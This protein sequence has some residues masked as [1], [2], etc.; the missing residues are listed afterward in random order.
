MK[1]I[2]FSLCTAGILF[3][4]NTLKA[5]TV[6][7]EDSFE[8]YTNF[9]I[10]NVGNWTLVDAD[11]SD[12]Y[13]IQGYSWTNAYAP[14]AFNVFNSTATTP[15]L[16]TTATS[17]WS[18]RTGQ[19]AMVS[20]AAI[21]PADGGSGPNNDWLIS[22][23]IQLTTDINNLSF[24]AKACNATYSAEKFRVY[25]STTDT[26]IDSFTPLS[27]IITTPAA[28]SWKE[29]SYNLNQYAGQQVYIAIQC[30]SEDQ[31][32]FAVDDFKVVSI[33]PATTAPGCTT[34]STPA[35]SAT[36]ISITPT[37]TWAA[38]TNADSYDV[39]LD[40]NT[41]PTTLVG[42]AP[43]TSYTLT[44]SLATNTKYYWKV[45]P[46]NSVGSASGCTV[47]SFTTLTVPNCATVTAPA[48]GAT[49]VAYQS[50]P[51][52]WTAPSGTSAA[53][54]YE[55]YLDKNTNPTTLVNTVTTTTYT[56]T[57]LDPSSTYYLKVIA[58]NTAGSATGC[59]VYSFTTM[60]PT[61]CTAGATSTSFEKISNVTFANIN[62]NSTATAGYEDFTSTIGNVTAGQT[63]TFTA[64]FTGTSYDKDHVLVWIDFNND[65]DFNDAGEQVLVT[66]TKKSPWT[67]SITI[68]AGATA[69]TTRM[70]V[71]LNDSG[72][73]TSNITPCGTSTFGQVEDY[74][75]N[76]GA[77]SVSDVNKADN[78]KA[79]PN[80]VK[81]VLKL[82]AAGNIKSVKVFDTTGKQIMTKELNEAK[83]QIDLSK[84]GTGVYV[85]TTTLADGTTTS[86]KV[87]KE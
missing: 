24:W 11:E 64:S 45:V 39:Y 54:S 74:T 13:G 5:Q 27:D 23:P 82:E 8:S 58:K 84:L 51:I 16:A 28:V 53:S 65:K 67:G 18:A 30:T 40:T 61:Y 48:N 46:K 57:N 85:V 81:D 36:G 62:K 75:L 73:S 19:K 14:Q 79:Y 20:F 2:L 71:R 49:N 83:S 26:S 32:G 22:P 59:T 77:L 33:P 66:A 37:L 34:L 6:I 15:A 31:F 47:Y 1:K 17:N 3:S 9:A 52:T 29:Y 10:A 42:N 44:T 69:T 43:S 70:R 80:P 55:V 12:T 76:I 87:I 7:F 86:T 4:A 35:N 25:V 56:A 41:D 72:S 50:L 63:Y 38:A 68:P 60:A 21:M 78:I